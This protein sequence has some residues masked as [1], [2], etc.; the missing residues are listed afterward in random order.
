[1]KR[2]WLNLIILHAGDGCISIEE[3]VTIV[4]NT[5]T[6]DIGSNTAAQELQELQDAFRVFDKMDRGYITSSDLRFV[7]QCLGEDL[8]E[9]E[10]RF[11][12]N[13][14]MKVLQLNFF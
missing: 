3:F 10:S 14:S 5:E 1:M 7:L 4:E 8:T 12:L 13:F 9:Q 11:E 6:T 2:A